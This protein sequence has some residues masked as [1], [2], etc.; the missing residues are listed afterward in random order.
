MALH[1]NVPKVFY[2]TD[3]DS[4]DGLGPVDLLGAS[5]TK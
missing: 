3:W 1:A 2:Q 5:Q 4:A